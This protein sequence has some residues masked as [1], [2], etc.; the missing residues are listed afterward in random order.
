MAAD[1]ANFH[2]LTNDATTVI[3][4]TD[5]A[6]FIA[7]CGHSVQVIDLAPATRIFDN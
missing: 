5:L 7:K 6:R 2:P 4:P 1:V 3:T